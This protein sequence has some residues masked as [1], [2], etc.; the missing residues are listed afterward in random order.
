MRR[1]GEAN[2]LE[3]FARVASIN[4]LDEL[5][6][7]EALVLAEEFAQ[8]FPKAGGGKGAPRER[9]RARLED[10]HR[11]LR[12]LVR[13]SETGDPFPLENL[14]DLDEPHG[15]VDPATRELE[16]ALPK[17]DGSPLAALRRVVRLGR[18]VPLRRCARDGC[19]AVFVPKRLTSKYHSPQCLYL[20]RLEDEGRMQQK[21]E[22]VRRARARAKGL[23]TDRRKR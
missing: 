4:S 13:S 9:P 12:D 14:L 18:R 5:S 23:T 17:D 10:I 8:L 7:G 16:L 3:F 2:L 11:R 15:I 21:R 19:G 6:D 20:A 22:A 1:T